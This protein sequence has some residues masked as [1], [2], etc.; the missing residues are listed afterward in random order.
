[1]LTTCLDGLVAGWLAGWVGGR[2]ALEE[3]KLRLTSAKVEVEV[4]AELG[5][6][7]NQTNGLE[8]WQDTHP[9]LPLRGSTLQGI[10][11]AGF[12]NFF[13]FLSPPI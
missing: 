5:K 10:L 6:K 3:W 8:E 1:M 7:I 11:Q 13:H 12:H 9:I 4:E 2:V